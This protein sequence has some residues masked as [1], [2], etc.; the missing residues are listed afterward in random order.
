MGLPGL[1]DSGSSAVAAGSAQN[2]RVSSGVCAGEWA[3]VH[4]MHAVRSIMLMK[5]ILE[6]LSGATRHELDTSG[7]DGGALRHNPGA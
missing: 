2:Q 4:A 1:G 3:H 5:Y 7:N 6:E